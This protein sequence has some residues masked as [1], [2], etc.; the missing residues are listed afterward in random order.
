MS[1][2]VTALN[3][4][5]L[6]ARP[7][8]RMP[9]DPERWLRRQ[10]EEFDPR[11]SEFDGVA[12]RTAI[13]AELA[14]WYAY[15]RQERQ[16]EG[17]MAPAS[18]RNE[19]AVAFGESGKR[20]Y[21][22]MVGARLESALNDDA[23][24]V[25]RL[26]HFWANHFA[27]SG[28]NSALLRFA[29]LLEFEAIRPHVLGRF[30]NMLLAVEQHPAMLLYLDQMQSIGPNSMF[31]ARAA[32][33]GRERGLN[34]NLG[35]EILELHSLGVDGGYD[36]ADV[37]ELSRALTGWTVGGLGRGP[38]QR[39]V[40]SESRPGDF[41]FL[42]QLHEPGSRRLLGRAY[43][44]AGVGQARS[45]LADLAAHPSTANH[46]ATK[47]ARHF[48]GDDPPAAL[49]QRLVRAYRESDGSL[50]EIYQALI[51]SRELWVE[52]PLKFK[53]PWEWSVSAMRA[54]DQ[55]RFRQ[56]IAGFSRQLGQAVW[57]P[58]SPAG[59]PDSDAHW[60]GSDA[61]MRRVDGAQR[62]V[63][64][65]QNPA[66]PRQ[67]AAAL[68]GER[69]SAQTLQAISRAESPGQGLALLLVSPEFL[70]R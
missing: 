8:E 44:E 13:A 10:F 32:G 25:E 7:D 12:T 41:V 15:R 4:F 31:G 62:L 36:Q 50:P 49:V 29:G 68:F 59:F 2:A 26:V 21:R 3:R 43:P 35:R 28:D 24:F 64:R 45:M 5:G 61:L 23:P 27:V 6:G 16:G 66:D 33:R 34:E 38:G 18:G 20:M 1:R 46:V 57:Q 14:D 70:W 54:L 51:D 42:P 22:E 58:R 67:L 19:R 39:F 60:L 47:L 37:T 53:S 48:A 11:P 56:G 9:A 65:A 69:M 17:A 30:A 52:T 40:D 55:T 63:A